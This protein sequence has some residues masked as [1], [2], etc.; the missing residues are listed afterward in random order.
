MG[1]NRNVTVEWR[2][3]HGPPPGGGGQ[4]IRSTIILGDTCLH[5]IIGT[6][7]F[8]VLGF[9]GG[10]NLKFSARQPPRCSILNVCNGYV[11]VGPRAPAGGAPRRVLS[12]KC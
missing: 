5:C 10:Q 7:N 2:L 3:S 6:V 12:V 4:R 8:K 1:S 11:T 9:E